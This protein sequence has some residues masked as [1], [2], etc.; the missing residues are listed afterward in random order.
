MLELG[1]AH[2]ALYADEQR[3]FARFLWR[4]KAAAITPTRHFLGQFADERRQAP[5]V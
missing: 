1:E 4:E 3:W 5:P 2:L